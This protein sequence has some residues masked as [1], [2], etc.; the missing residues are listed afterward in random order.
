MECPGEETRDAPL[1]LYSDMDAY[2]VFAHPVRGRVAGYHI[3]LRDTRAHMT[4]GPERLTGLRLYLR[5]RQ[6]CAGTQSHYDV[7]H[8]KVGGKR[9]GSALCFD[10]IRQIDS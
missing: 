2:P 1:K 5:N 8:A 9:Y 4:I 10:Y 3:V 7:K 6:V